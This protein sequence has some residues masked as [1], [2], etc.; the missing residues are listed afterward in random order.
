MTRY[1]WNRDKRNGTE[2]RWARAHLTGEHA[3]TSSP[4]GGLVP[5]AK[6]RIITLTSPWEISPLL[7]PA[8]PFVPIAL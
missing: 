5:L 4:L 8:F 2:T 1:R 7:R 3:I 6:T